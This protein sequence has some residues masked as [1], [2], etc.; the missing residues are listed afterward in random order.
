MRFLWKGRDYR[1]DQLGL[2]HVYSQ[3]DVLFHVFSVISGST[4][5]RLV[6]NAQTLLW[7]LE[8]VSSE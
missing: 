1:I 2:H 6:L 5:F 7:R 8:E 4:Y 3:G